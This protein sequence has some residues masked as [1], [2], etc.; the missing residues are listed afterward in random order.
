[1]IAKR[2]AHT[3]RN[4]GQ[5]GLVAM[6]LVAGCRRDISGAYLASDNTA[7]CWLELVR[8]PDNHL[9]GQLSAYTL[10]P[11]GTI[12]QSSTAVTGAVD[13]ENATLTATRL[14][15]LETL[16]FSGTLKGDTLT[17]TGSQP[18]PVMFNRSTLSDYQAKIADLNSRSQSIL[19]IKAVAQAQQRVFQVQAT[20]VS[21]VNRLIG[22]MVQFDTQAD[23]HLGQFPGAEKGFEAI[24]ARIEQYVS[25]ERQLA[26]NPNA[27][28]TRGQLSV[29]ASQAEIQTEQGHNQTVALESSMASNVK[30]IADQATNDE[31]D[32][33]A[34]AQNSGNLAQDELQ[35]V[36][37]AC[38]RLES[39][40][41]PFRQKYEA[42]NAGLAHLEQVYQQEHS[43]QQ[44]LIQESERLE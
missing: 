40:S 34:V 26:G 32:C 9:T 17:L 23:V 19:H 27:G 30:P 44:Q 36:R 33:H 37:G 10:K 25:R 16:T 5:C 29:A 38:D 43:K 1:M 7:A 22:Q 12:A 2:V 31:R 18:I 42:M 11:D 35:N 4:V 3:I 20:F 14:L 24:T 13:G 28:A 41:G 6:L 15:G 8:T 39:A 21:K